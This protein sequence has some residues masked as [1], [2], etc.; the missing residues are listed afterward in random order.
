MSKHD[1]NSAP[2]SEDSARARLLQA[3]LRL[4]AEKGFDATTTREIASESGLNVSLISYY[5][6][7]KEGLY[8]KAIEDYAA[9]V[10]AQVDQ[11]EVMVRE[12]EGLTRERFRE[13]MKFLIEGTLQAHIDFPE[14][15]VVLFRELSSGMTHSREYFDNAFFPII[16]ILKAT[17]EEAQRKRIV[18]KNINPVLYLTMVVHAVDSFVMMSRQDTQCRQYLPKM[19]EDRKILVDHLLTVALEGGLV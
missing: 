8:R 6:G 15:K 7:G 18:K 11:I 3:G 19:P 16:Q 12:G 1:S 14:M 9:S 13:F 17:V 2:G 4:F 5:F 10:R